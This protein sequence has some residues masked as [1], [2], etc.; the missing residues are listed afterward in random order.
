[1]RAPWAPVLPHVIEQHGV[2]LGGRRRV[3]EYLDRLLD[4]VDESFA[5]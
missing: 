3:G 4:V 5:R 2:L 1:M